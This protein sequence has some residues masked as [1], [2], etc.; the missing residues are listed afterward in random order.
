MAVPAMTN[1]SPQLGDIAWAGFTIQYN[2]VGYQIGPGSTSQRWVWWRYSINTIQ[3]G[4][5]IPVDLTDDD[6]VLFG[7]KNGIAIRV[8]SSTLIDGELVVD[9][10]ILARAVSAEVMVANEVFSREGYFG[11]IGVEQLKS[12]SL[13]AQIALL[14]SLGVGNITIA[15][16]R[17]VV[18]DADYSPGGILIPQNTGGAILLPAD[19]S[20]AKF[21]GTVETKNL[22]VEGG[23]NL[24]GLA[25]FINGKLVLGSGTPD[26]IGQTELGYTMFPKN[27]GKLNV[28]SYDNS[29]RGVAK[30]T[31]GHYATVIP[32]GQNKGSSGLAELVIMDPVTKNVTKTLTQTGEDLAFKSVTAVGNVFYVLGLRW[33]AVAGAAEFRIHAYNTD[34]TLASS[35]W[36]NDTTGARLTSA[37]LDWGSAISSEGDGT[38]LR[39]ARLQANG[40]LQLWRFPINSATPDD[41]ALSPSGTGATYLSGSMYVG[42]ADFGTTADDAMAVVGVGFGGAYRMAAFSLVT[43]AEVPANSFG[44][45]A[46]DGLLWDGTQFV[47][48][49]WDTTGAWLSLLSTTK[50]DTTIYAQHDWTNAAGTKRSKPTTVASRL[51]P[52]RTWPTLVAPAPPKTGN[53]PDIADRVNLYLDT[54]NVT[55]LLTTVTT[56]A[57]TTVI[58]TALSGT[59]IAPKLATDLT[60]F[61]ATDA[62]GALESVL[63]NISLKG[64]GAWKLGE[65]IGT[66]D[67]RFKFPISSVQ[68]PTGATYTGQITFV[69]QGQVVRA[70]GY[71]DRASGFNATSHLVPGITIPVGWR[72]AAT[73]IGKAYPVWNAAGSYRYRFQPDGTVE[74]QQSVAIAAFETFDEMW[75]VA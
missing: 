48:L 57:V 39:V 45:S 75:I 64:D 16:A 50:V 72:P 63:Q 11:S 3:A 35:R 17:G 12:G 14:G 36:I 69:R 10:S 60:D 22:T 53:A 44:T 4:P 49:D 51:I 5:D 18:G 47:T 68:T 27:G 65:L 8:Q 37:G 42:K 23:L 56:G 9:G 30:T 24:N 1:N 58:A 55:K 20:P 25:N 38:H 41:F 31:S 13:E 32:W 19:G 74:V 71:V 61:A 7:N 43:G 21:V 70:F 40:R 34:G 73:V 54:D 26:P 52:K 28:V 15:P 33:D 29:S 66:N 6:L 2:G 62:T 46:L 59:G 67:G